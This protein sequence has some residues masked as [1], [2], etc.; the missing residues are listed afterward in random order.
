M[1]T[2]PRMMARHSGLGFFVYALA[3]ASV[4]GVV[5]PVVS[6]RS[7]VPVAAKVTEAAFGTMPDGT[8]VRLFTL[9]NAA[10]ME[11]RATTYGVI[12]VSIKVPDR[13]GHLDDIVIGHENLEG[14]L[15]KS[16]YFGAVVGR[17][18]NRIAGGHVTIDGQT[19]NLT[20]NNGPNHLHGGLKGFD[21]TVWN[22]E[23]ANDP[24]GASVVFTHTS[25]DGHEG[26]PGTLAARVVYTVTDKNEL[27]IE[28]SATTD[29]PTIVNLTQHS[30][31]NLAGDGS[32]D[33]LGH[34]LTLHAD[35]YTP[36]DANQIPTG[37]LAPVEGTPFDFRRETPIGER[38][39]ADH[40]QIK[41]SGGLRPQLGADAQRQRP[42]ARR[43]RRRAQD[44]PDDGD[45]DDRAGHPVLFR[46]QARRV[47]G[48]EGRPRLPR[49]HGLLRR[50]AAFSRL[51]EQAEFS[52]DGAATGGAVQVDDGVQVR[53]GV[54][55]S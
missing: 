49:A 52:V 7:S 29:K 32:G 27:I 33:V 17:Y 39:D 40:P 23:I 42:R 31:F 25:P 34:R 51:A 26:Y 10:G 46:Q 2:E 30:Y 21:K 19:Y 47:D 50:D 20:L 8:A 41:M 9:T 37:E 22:A 18:G 12:L 14:Y 16:R 36:V 55:S 13:Q 53:R 43:P 11:V 54:R 6:G 38:I 15:T 5:N 28:Y 3:I 48:R 1:F 45:H 35:R 24:R 4:F 44:R